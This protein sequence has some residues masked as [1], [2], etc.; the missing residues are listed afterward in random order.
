MIYSVLFDNQIKLWWD[1]NK[2]YDGDFYLIKKDG[3]EF[4]TTASHYSFKDLTP[5]TTYSFSVVIKNEKGETLKEIGCADFATLKAKNVLDVTKEP[6]NAIPDGTTLNTKAIQK[7]IDDCTEN[8]LVFFPD[9]VYLTGALNLHSNVELRLSDNATLQ[10]SEDEKDYLPKIP[11]RFEGWEEEAYR[12]LINTGTLDPKNFDYCCENVTIRGGKILG[13]GQKLRLNQINAEKISVL[14]EY[15]YEND[16][17]PPGFYARSLPGRRRGRLMQFSNTKNILIADCYMGNGP[18]WNIH[19]IYCKDFIACDCTVYS[20]AI[21]NGDGINPDSTENSLIFGI[22]FDTGDDFVAIKSGRNKVGY[23]VG[24]P[25]KNV[26]VFDCTCSDGHGV[27]VGSEMS[28]GVEDVTIWNC[29]FL[30]AAVG[31]SLKTNRERGGYIKNVSAYNCVTRKLG[32]NVYYGNNDGEPAPYPPVIENIHFEDFTICGIARST[33]TADFGNK[34]SMGYAVRFRSEPSYKAKNISLKNITL[35]H[36]AVIPFQD[37]TAEN[38]ENFT[39]ENIICMGEDGK[40][41]PF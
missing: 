37:L 3:E 12:S 36:R 18:S 4:T 31:V 39:I 30:K 5:N 13:G 28:G 40:V 19:P 7:A 24:R 25:T 20:H 22:H 10:G 17:N 11:S 9:G 6:Y 34:Y 15:G 2:L 33:P 8:D 1:Y 32:L 14:K 38:V 23:L 35:L 21:S 16:P 26:K 29:Y 41:S 27:A